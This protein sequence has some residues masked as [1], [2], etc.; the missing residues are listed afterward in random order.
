LCRAPRARGVCDRCHT[1]LL[2]LVC[3]QSADARPRKLATKKGKRPAADPDASDS[4]S[5]DSE[6]SD[7][8]GAIRRQHTVCWQCTHAA[9]TVL[10]QLCASRF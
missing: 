5:S 1:H 8:S 10:T 2:R 6:D 4:S 9:T 3:P 7:A